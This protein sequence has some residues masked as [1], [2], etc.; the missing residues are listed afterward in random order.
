MV[1]A[2]SS[3]RESMY[4]GENILARFPERIIFSLGENDADSLVENVSVSG[5]R[6]NTV[7]FT[8]GIRNTFQLKPYVLPRNDRLKAFFDKIS[9]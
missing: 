1:P 3:V 7:Y 6:D 2:S 4:Y 9:E 8:D 5:L